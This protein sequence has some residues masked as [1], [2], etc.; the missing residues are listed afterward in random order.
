MD[1][2]YS[3]LLG[4]KTTGCGSS[5]ESISKS[6]KNTLL[7][8]EIAVPIV[9][10]GVAAALVAWFFVVPKAKTKYQVWKQNKRGIGTDPSYGEGMDDLHFEKVQPRDVH[11]AAGKFTMEF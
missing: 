3:V 5:V 6:N 7:A 2:S 11:T 9:V 1:P 4:D 10:V 8:V